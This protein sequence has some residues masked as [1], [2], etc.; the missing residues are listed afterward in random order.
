MRKIFLA[1]ICVFLSFQTWAEPSNADIVRANVKCA[2]EVEKIAL[3]DFKW[4]DSWY[5]PKFR[6][7]RHDMNEGV[8][9]YRT[10][11]IRFLDDR[12]LWIRAV[13]YCKWSIANEY[14]TEVKCEGY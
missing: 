10:D 12:G 6:K 7:F 5:E 4:I 8:Y 9:I 3:Y 13:C 11:N 2:G 14:V 1:V